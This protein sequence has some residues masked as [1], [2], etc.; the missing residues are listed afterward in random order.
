MKKNNTVYVGFAADLV[1]HGHVN[2]IKVA[3]LY[4]EVVVGL[5][6][7]RAILSYK[8][9]PFMTYKQRKFVIENFKGVKKVIQQ[10]T[11]DYSSNLIKTK[12]HYV[13]HGDDWK[14]GPQ[15]QIRKKVIKVLSEW[16]GKLIEVP[17]TKGISTT[18]I[19]SKLKKELTKRS[20]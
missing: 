2:I 17:Y 15:K 7:D 6:T 8:R 11:H 5:L 12:P 20:A 14:K 19:L 13:V 16:N 9:K 1:H 3:R 4:G 10:T 18:K